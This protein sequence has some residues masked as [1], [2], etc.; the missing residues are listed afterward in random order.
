MASVI[1]SINVK[2]PMTK[3]KAGAFE[4]NKTTLDA[5]KDNL[6]ILI[7]SNYRRK[8]YSL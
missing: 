4:T 8:M 3:G 5:I 6:K 2:F 7:L 1:N